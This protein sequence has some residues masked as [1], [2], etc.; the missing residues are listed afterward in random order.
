MAED[1]TPPGFTAVPPNG[2]L[3]KI[4]QTLFFAYLFTNGK[5]LNQY[6]RGQLEIRDVPKEKHVLVPFPVW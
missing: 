1:S 6:R 5:S 2:S 3:F 4:H